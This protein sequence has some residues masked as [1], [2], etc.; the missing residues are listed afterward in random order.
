MEGKLKGCILFDPVLF[1]HCTGL[2][3]FITRPQAI[4]IFIFYLSI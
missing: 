3:F 4:D 2:G 1:V